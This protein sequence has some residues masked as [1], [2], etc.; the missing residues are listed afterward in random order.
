MSS[1]IEWGKR[2]FGLRL[3]ITCRQD[4]A[5]F[6]FQFSSYRRSNG[7][8]I[9]VCIFL[10]YVIFAHMLQCKQSAAITVQGSHPVFFA[11]LDSGQSV[12]LSSLFCIPCQMWYITKNGKSVQV[13][14][15]FLHGGICCDTK[16][17]YQDASCGQ[18]IKVHSQ[19]VPVI[20]EEFQM[21]REIKIE[22]ALLE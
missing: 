22:C 2:F 5:S 20:A 9:L 7:L 21:L 13:L 15:C 6:R 14:P 16:L 17:L 12:L 3:Q 1:C 10:E 8:Q 4:E 18:M 19:H 11:A